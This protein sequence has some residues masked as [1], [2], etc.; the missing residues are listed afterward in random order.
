[1]IRFIL[2]CINL[3][4]NLGRRAQPPLPQTEDT[5]PDEDAIRVI[6]LVMERAEARIAFQSQNIDSHDVK[7]L[8]FIALNLAGAGL[9]VTVRDTLQPWWWVPLI[10]LAI[11][12]ACFASTLWPRE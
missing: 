9:L 8:A 10:G 3:A 6:G 4:R 7:V 11:S 1:M 12:T 2:Q 5:N